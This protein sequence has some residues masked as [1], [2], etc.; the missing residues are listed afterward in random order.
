MVWENKI[1]LLESYFKI[2]TGVQGAKK[3]VCRW[4]ICETFSTKK[5]ARVGFHCGAKFI[6]VN[7]NSDDVGRITKGYHS[8]DSFVP[9]SF[10]HMQPGTNL[11]PQSST[12]RGWWVYVFLFWI[13]LLFTH[14]IFSLLLCVSFVSDGWTEYLWQ[15]LYRLYI[16]R[17]MVKSPNESWKNLFIQR[18]MY[19]LSQHGYRSDPRDIWGHY[20]ASASFIYAQ[21]SAVFL[22]LQF[23]GLIH[24]CSGQIPRWDR[25]H[26]HYEIELNDNDYSCC[27]PMDRQL[28]GGD[29]SIR[30]TSSYS[31]EG[32]YYIEFLVA[33][34]NSFF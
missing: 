11:S 13:L 28:V 29:R 18:C 23:V 22:V 32:I 8:I 25:N 33:R 34:G 27:I 19:I 1:R 4:K 14:I 31:V 2:L 24:L 21:K 6:F 26:K 10:V 15:G 16:D 3:Q 20:V 17:S 12:P 7:Q 5:K 30:L 9:S